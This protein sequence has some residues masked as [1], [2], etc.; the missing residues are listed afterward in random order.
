MRDE[1]KKFSQQPITDNELFININQKSEIRKF[2]ITDLMDGNFL[3]F[4]DRKKHDIFTNGIR[5]V[6]MEDFQTVTPSRFS[7]FTNN[8]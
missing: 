6:S 7:C 3:F 5:A 4:F 1:L 2:S 8:C